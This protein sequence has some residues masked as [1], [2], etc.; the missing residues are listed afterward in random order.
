[1]TAAQLASQL[2]TAVL[3]LAAMTVAAWAALLAVS[4][5]QDDG[6]RF[7]GPGSVTPD[8]LEAVLADLEPSR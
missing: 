6:P 4:D 7:D 1:M 2:L 5:S 8:D 3:F